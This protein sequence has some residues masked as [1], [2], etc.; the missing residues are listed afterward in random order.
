MLLDVLDGLVD[1]ECGVV[2]LGREAE[3]RRAVVTGLPGGG[4]E[5]FHEFGGDGVALFAQPCC[6]GRRAPDRL[7]VVD[8]RVHARQDAVR[9]VPRGFSRVSALGRRVGVAEK[10]RRVSEFSRL[11]RPVG[12][13][14]GERG[15]ICGHAM[16]ML[17]HAGV[18]ARTRRTAR[19]GVREMVG[20]QDAVPGQCVEIRGL[21]EVAQYREAVA[22]PLVRR[23]EQDVAR[24]GGCVVG[25]R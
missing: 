20:E 4:R 5:K 19:R 15:A 21:D 13:S 8:D 9:D 2:Q 24:H 7:A 25:H 18:D 12:V 23:D 17:A 14:R 11:Q 3:R 10:H 1:Q 16:P 22:A 6:P